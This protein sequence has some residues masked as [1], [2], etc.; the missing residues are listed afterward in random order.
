MS[1]RDSSSNRSTPLS[2]RNKA[3]GIVVVIGIIGFL[4][5]FFVEVAIHQP[6]STPIVVNRVLLN[7]TISV[8]VGVYYVQFI[9]PSA[10]F[11][12]QVSGNFTVSGGNN[13][14]V[15]VM[16]EANFNNLGVNGF[17]FAPDYNSGQV[18]TGDINATLR[19][20]GTYYLVYDNSFQASQKIVNTFVHLGYLTF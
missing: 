13:I 2:T 18:A 19:S 4:G 8:N 20:S 7:G 14:R 12:V 9:I 15:Y 11:N 17:N 3:V 16:N 10:A 5:V 6:V 1:S